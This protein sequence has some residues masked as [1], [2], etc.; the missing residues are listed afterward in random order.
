MF[1]LQLF[2]LISEFCGLL[3][4]LSVNR[5]LKFVFK[6]V[7]LFF[8]FILLGYL[9]LGSLSAVGSPSVYALEEGSSCFLNVS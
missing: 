2:Y 6:L 7:K 3:I 8:L 9:A 5:L 1:T 4:F